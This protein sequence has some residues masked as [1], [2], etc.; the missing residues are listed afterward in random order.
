MLFL[1]NQRNKYLLDAAHGF[2]LE[3]WSE[4]WYLMGKCIYALHFRL[5]TRYSGVH[6]CKSEL[7]A[8]ARSAH[9]EQFNAF[10][11][12]FLYWLARVPV[13]PITR[14]RLQD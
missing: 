5:L 8:S 13:C 2:V 14:A 4:H 12:C 6:H 9:D 11:A 7:P 10:A 3:C 1:P